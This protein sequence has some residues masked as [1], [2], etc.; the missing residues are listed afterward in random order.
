MSPYDFESP[1]KRAYG[2]FNIGG[3]ALVSGNLTVDAGM[4]LT[5]GRKYGNE[6]S[7]QVALN[8]GF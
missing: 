6:T 5:V 7:G 4:S 3:T 2:R 8:L 1:S